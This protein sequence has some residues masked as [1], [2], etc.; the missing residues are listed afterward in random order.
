MEQTQ[1]PNILDNVYRVHMFHARVA[2]ENVNAEVTSVNAACTWFNL[3]HRS[4]VVRELAVNSEEWCKARLRLGL[5]KFYVGRIFH[6][7]T[8]SG[9]DYFICP[10]NEYHK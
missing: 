9:F 4:P 3:L 5:L 10:S 6:V 8:W 7:V 2:D 1:T